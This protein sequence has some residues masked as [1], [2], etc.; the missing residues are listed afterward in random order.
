MR[1]CNVRRIAFK[2]VFSAQN[3]LAEKRQKIPSQT[4]EKKVIFRK[5]KSKEV[6]SRLN[7]T[8]KCIILSNRKLFYI[9]SCRWLL[10]V[11]N[12]VLFF[13]QIN[14]DATHVYKFR[15][16]DGV[17]VCGGRTKIKSRV[18]SNKVIHWTI[19]LIEI[20]L[21]F[22]KQ[23]SSKKCYH[24]SPLDD[25]GRKG[26]MLPLEGSEIPYPEDMDKISCDEWARRDGRLGESLVLV[27]AHV[28]GASPRAVSRG[29]SGWPTT[30]RTQTGGTR[31]III[32]I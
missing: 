7:N 8:Y 23:N 9:L 30:P 3:H 6:A 15:V 22:F 10:G 24:W 11:Y 2:N 19:N 27:V 1:S 16:S 29:Q 25:K 13:A 14:F 31:R 4:E 28:S 12:T 21:D 5:K 26:F 20:L 32:Q 17:V 18:V